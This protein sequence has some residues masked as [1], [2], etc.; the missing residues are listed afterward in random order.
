MTNRTLYF[1][2]LWLGSCLHKLRLFNGLGKMGKMCKQMTSESNLPSCEEISS[3]QFTI[4]SGIFWCISESLR[5]RAK[6]SSATTCH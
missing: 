6:V 4:L 2:L 1:R 5:T 3:D